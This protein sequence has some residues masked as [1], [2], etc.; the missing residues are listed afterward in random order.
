MGASGTV[1]RLRCRPT[2]SATFWT[3]NTS[4]GGLLQPVLR[5]QYSPVHHDRESVGQ[6]RRYVQSSRLA[7]DNQAWQRT[8][9]PIRRVWRILHALCNSAPA[10]DCQM[11]TGQWS[12]RKTE[13]VNH[14]TCAHSPGSMSELEERTADVCGKVPVLYRIVR[15]TGKSRRRGWVIRAWDTLIMST[16]RRAEGCEFN[17]RPGQ[18]SRM[19]F[20]SDQ[21]TGT[22]F[23]YLNMPFLPN[24]K[25]I[26]A[27]KVILLD[28]LHGINCSLIQEP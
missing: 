7:D 26:L 17:P 12:S 27:L 5:V 22:V 1:D 18:Y 10:C 24:S 4:C 19:R 25:F 3:L 13:C 28:R 16:P 2:R 14:E 8:A 9:I 6:S 11:G 20:W 21:V 15:T 23:P